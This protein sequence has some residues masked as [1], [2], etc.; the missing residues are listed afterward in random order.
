MSDIIQ[1][2]TAEHHA[3]VSLLPTEA[4]DKE[5]SDRLHEVNHLLNGYYNYNKMYYRGGY[6]YPETS[7]HSIGEHMREALKNGAVKRFFMPTHVMLGV[8][9][10][11]ALSPCTPYD[12]NNKEHQQMMREKYAMRLIVDSQ[13]IAY[14]DERFDITASLSF[15]YYLDGNMK[16]ANLDIYVRDG[17]KWQVSGVN[18]S[19]MGTMDTTLTAIYAEMMLIACA[20]HDSI[21]SVAMSIKHT[22]QEPID[23]AP[24]S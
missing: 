16:E 15:S 3:L 13:K 18:W 14:G 12:Y 10:I 5:R 21:Y 2:L 8:D 1:E 17:Y 23:N 9:N 22:K 20:I 24:Q 4:W 11:M 7:K 19:A 6:E